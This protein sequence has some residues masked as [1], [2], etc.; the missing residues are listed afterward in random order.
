MQGKEVLI[1]YRS[2]DK[3]RV[4]AF[5]EEIEDMIGRKVC[6][7]FATDT[8]VQVDQ[9]AELIAA[10]R[11]FILV[12][13]SAYDQVGAIERKCIEGALRHLSVHK[14]KRVVLLS[15]D[16][17]QE[18]EWLESLL[19][20]QQVTMLSN[21]NALN[22]FY[23][24]LYERLQNY[25]IEKIK[26]LPKGVFKVGDLYYRAVHDGTVVEVAP[27]YG[28]QYPEDRQLRYFGKDQL[29]HTSEKQIIGELGLSDRFLLLTASEEQ[30]IDE[31]VIPDRI[32]Y[33]G[34]EYDVVGIG[35]SA[36]SYSYGFR[37]VVIPDTVRYI[38]DWAFDDC[39][40]ETVDMPDSITEIGRCSF[41]DCR[42]LQSVR[43][44]SGLVSIGS[45]AFADCDMLTSVVIPSGVHTLLEGAFRDCHIT[46]ATIPDTMTKIEVNALG[47][48]LEYITVDEN[49]PKYDSRGGCNAVIETATGALIACSKNTVIPDGVRFVSEGISGGLVESLVF[50]NG[51]LAVRKNAFR[52]CSDLKSVVLPDSVMIIEDY[53]FLD[54]NRLSSVTLGR[55]IIKIGESAFYNLDYHN[56]YDVNCLPI[57]YVPKGMKARYAGL[58]HE[59][60]GDRIIEQ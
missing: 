31:L 24:T 9:Y 14:D 45:S 26:A 11:I 39:R 44:S 54:C 59:K 2:V 7:V 50:P 12:C 36:F 56:N 34:Y 43:L 18:P 42:C 20:K 33:G 6:S 28:D 25:A 37:T 49:N 40:I 29:T 8:M 30:I 41:K 3:E 53:A 35:E 23:V 19:P 57:I 4:L 32:S 13:S 10:C 21:K 1:S 15:I 48:F 51:L 52:F 16:S 27:E 47:D 17:P 46:H 38:G 5:K 55:N 58:L 22:V 60:F